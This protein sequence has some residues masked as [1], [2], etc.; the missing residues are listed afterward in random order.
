MKNKLKASLPIIAIAS[1]IMVKTPPALAI[2]E[3]PVFW[4]NPT[5]RTDPDLRRKVRKSTVSFGK[6]AAQ[7]AIEQSYSTQDELFADVKKFIDE[8]PQK[9][10][11]L[12]VHGCC[13]D[14]PE[15]LSAAKILSNSMNM[16]VLLYAWP[17]TP[18]HTNVMSA[19]GYHANEQAEL[20]T[21][22]KFGF[23]FGNFEN[24]LP[25]HGRI[26]VMAHSMGNRLLLRE[27]HTNAT[28][29]KRSERSFIPFKSIIFANADIGATQF[30]I[31]DAAH[32]GRNS[33]QIIVL[34]NRNDKALL[35]SSQMHE[36]ARMGAVGRGS[37]TRQTNVK[38]PYW[39]NYPKTPQIKVV[40]YT[41][42]TKTVSLSV[43]HDIPIDLLKQLIS[44][45]D[46]SS[47]PLR[48]VEWHYYVPGTTNNTN[49][50]K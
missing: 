42:E 27:L 1:A 46:W 25:E 31:H 35:A 21:E 29:I 17:A 24:E 50:V 20:D 7:G 10:L 40:D 28:L 11:L 23:F 44:T 47:L 8:H 30:E 16:P 33:N 32:I 22:L 2:E 15:S 39:Q 6:S 3:D 43:E 34:I 5:A 12:Y 18:F 49:G 19:F 38:D 48:Q 4:A 41:D 37:N 9:T 14:F 36:G 26:V 45:D 13:I